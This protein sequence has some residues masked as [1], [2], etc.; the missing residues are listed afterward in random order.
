MRRGHG[1]Y[2]DRARTARP[3]PTEG[4]RSGRHGRRRDHD[5]TNTDAWRLHVIDGPDRLDGADADNWDGAVHRRY[6]WTETPPSMAV[7]EAVADAAGRDMTAIDPLYEHFAP[8]ALDA[9]V[10]SNG[11]PTA[12]GNT[13]VSFHFG[14]Y[15]VTVAGD[16][17][18]I[19]RVHAA[20]A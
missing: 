18:V 10:R 7:V 8:D 9:L 11:G 16:G 12:D 3:V 14:D 4:G 6:D 20:D 17:G 13:T 1:R 15:R 5:D 2:R 19:V